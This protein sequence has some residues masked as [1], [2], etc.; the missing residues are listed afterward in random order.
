M[1]RVLSFQIYI[2]SSDFRRIICLTKLLSDR[3][4]IKL[5]NL[6]APTGTFHIFSQLSN[7]AL[8]AFLF[9]MLKSH[10]ILEYWYL[11]AYDPIFISLPSCQTLLLNNLRSVLLSFSFWKYWS[12]KWVEMTNSI[13]LY[14]TKTW[15]ENSIQACSWIGHHWAWHIRPSQHL[16]VQ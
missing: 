11:M 3:L 13:D 8:A 2:P 4:R 16:Q 6:L 9:P 5:S 1:T 7:P 15:N 14:S 12:S 10:F